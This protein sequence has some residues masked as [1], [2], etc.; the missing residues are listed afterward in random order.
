[1][2][3]RDHSGRAGFVR[4]QLLGVKNE[5]PSALLSTGVDLFD[6]KHEKKVF[7]IERTI[8]LPKRR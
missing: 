1:M 5:R 7:E 4:F 8:L 3:K 6:S 2:E